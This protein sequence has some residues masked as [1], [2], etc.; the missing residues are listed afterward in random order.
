MFKG[1]WFSGQLPL[2]A[3]W[4][5]LDF[6]IHGLFFRII[7]AAA[8]IRLRVEICNPE[9]MCVFRRDVCRLVGNMN[10][11]MYWPTCIVYTEAPRIL[12]K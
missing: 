2:S 11:C 10:M 12:N 8:R 9:K 3:A 1:G 5:I 6:Y 7:S 4:I